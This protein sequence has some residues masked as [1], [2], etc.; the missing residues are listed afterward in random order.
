MFSKNISS[1]FGF[2]F[3][4]KNIRILL[5]K[6]SKICLEILNWKNFIRDQ[7]QTNIVPYPKVKQPY[8]VSYLF[9][10]FF[11][12]PIVAYVNISCKIISKLAIGN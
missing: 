8:L 4:T 9:I 5:K 3:Y 7:K 10:L 1:V 6:S 2:S 11:F 12:C